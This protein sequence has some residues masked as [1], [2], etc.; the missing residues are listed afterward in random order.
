MEE[1]FYYIDALGGTDPTA[2]GPFGTYQERDGAAREYYNDALE[3]SEDN[4]FW[5]DIREDG[6][7]V[8]GSYQK[9]DLVDD[10]EEV[11]LATG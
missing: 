1:K 6:E 9:S 10:P 8:V 4:I 3:Q 2:V 11:D 5:A 7:L